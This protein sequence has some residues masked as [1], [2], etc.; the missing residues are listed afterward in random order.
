MIRQMST[1]RIAADK[2][3]EQ[4]HEI[5][6]FP[7]S[8][9]VSDWQQGG[10]DGCHWHWHKDLELMYVVSGQVTAMAKALYCKVVTEF[11][12]IPRYFIG[13]RLMAVSPVMSAILSSTL[14]WLA[15]V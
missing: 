14:N 2:E 11:L 8:A 12:S 3:K 15:V 7:C 1:M 6:L 4:C 9:Y 5:P 13:I 10:I